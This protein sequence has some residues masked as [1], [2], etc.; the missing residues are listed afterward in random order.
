MEKEKMQISTSILMVRPARFGFNPLTA[1]TNS[2]QGQ[3]SGLNPEQ[4]SEKARE[5]FDAL[6]DLLR[7]KGVKVVV[8]SD[9]LEP[10]KPD[11][12][13]PNNWISLHA[14]GRVVLYPM[15]A[16][17]RRT[18]RRPEIIGLLDRDYQVGEVVDLSEA[19]K[20]GRYL[21]G[22]GSM[23]LDHDNRL[24]YACLSPRTDPRLLKDFCRR[25]HYQPVAFHAFDHTGGAVYHTNVMLCIGSGFAVLAADAIR[26]EEERYVVM[27]S[28]RD[29]GHEVVTI[30]M[31]QMHHFAGNML[32]VKNQAGQRFLVMSEQARLS[33]RPDQVQ[34]LEQHAEILATS[35]DTIEQIGGGSARC[36]MAEIFLPPKS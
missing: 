4:V 27:R 24:A 22:T 8:A 31:D 29:T 3:L 30:S 33:L 20:Q 10:E 5:E 12:V 9:T 6:V 16:A 25:F 19:E 1:E 14:D 13:F 21:E 35:L 18:E 2:F 34:T 23:V 7:E 28:L 36:M 11:A 15:Q 32:E 26:E 17:S